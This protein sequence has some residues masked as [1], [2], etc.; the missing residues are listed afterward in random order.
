M[1]DAIA[2]LGIFG[3]C[4][5]K[6]V[7]KNQLIALNQELV[8]VG[9]ACNLIIYPLIFRKILTELYNLIK[10]LFLRKKLN[11]NYFYCK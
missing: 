8:F 10:I 3:P 7:L 11:K 5:S 2:L 9:V 1:E 4:N 6:N